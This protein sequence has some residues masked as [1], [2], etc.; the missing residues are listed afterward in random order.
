MHWIFLSLTGAFAQAVGAAIKKKALQTSGMNNIIGF[1]SFAFAGIIFWVLFITGSGSFWMGDLSPLFWQAMAWY[2]G[3]NI[4][5]VWFMYRALDI[6]EFNHLMPYMTV[7]SLSLVVPPMIFLGESPSLLSFGGI[8]LIVCGA[9]AMNYKGSMALDERALKQGDQRRAN[10]TGV[11]YFLVTALCFT[12]TP[13]AQKIAVQESSVLF[14]SFVVHSLIALGFLV[15]LLVLRERS[16]LSSVLRD[17][18]KREFLMAV[19]AAGAVVVLENGSI[20][21]ALGQ[22]SVAYVFAFKRMMP[23]F[24]FVIGIVYFRE[25]TDLRKKFVATALMVVGALAM[26]LF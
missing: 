20:N 24:A 9:I 11:W 18:D 7:T 25:R 15:I 8:A 21:A 6:A 10:R 5:A 2:A 3:L 4:L 19:V 22:A 14:A 16:K 17:S 1:L 13:T 23:F 26:T 12:F